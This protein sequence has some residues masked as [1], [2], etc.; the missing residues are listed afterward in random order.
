MPH[1]R[2][3]PPQSANSDAHLFTIDIQTDRHEGYI[4]RVINITLDYVPLSDLI[5]HGQM[6]AAPSCF[7]RS[8]RR[9]D[10]SRTTTSTPVRLNE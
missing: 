8:G 7:L 10:Q 4:E 5:E 6:W 3:D 9:N 1:L 2:K